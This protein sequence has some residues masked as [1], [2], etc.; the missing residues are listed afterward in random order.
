MGENPSRWRVH[1]RPS[2]RRDPRTAA[3][4]LAEVAMSPTPGST[5]RFPLS[6]AQSCSVE[7]P[8]RRV[9]PDHGTLG[10]PAGSV[11]GT[12]YSRS[13]WTQTP[14]TTAVSTSTSSRDGNGK[15]SPRSPTISMLGNGPPTSPPSVWTTSSRS[16]SPTCGRG[17]TSSWS[18]GRS[19]DR[20]ARRRVLCYVKRP[21]G[22]PA[23]LGSSSIPGRPIPG[24][25]SDPT[26]A[27][28]PNSPTPGCCATRSGYGVPSSSTIWKE[29]PTGPTGCYPT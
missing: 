2:M 16:A 14:T 19:P 9:V 29:P 21:S 13:G 15:S 4:R 28:R 24:R 26:T 18:S 22:I 3:R 12:P 25:R 1:R 17:R 6:V 23:P 7:A 5:P 10:T 27:S 8:R 11:T 20:T